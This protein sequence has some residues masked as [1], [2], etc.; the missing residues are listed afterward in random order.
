M[1]SILNL[2]RSLAFYCLRFLNDISKRVFHLISSSNKFYNVINPVT[3]VKYL[4][5]HHWVSGP[6]DRERPLVE[7]G[8]SGEGRSWMK[9]TSGIETL[10]W[11]L[12]L[13]WR[14]VTC[15]ISLP[16]E[17]EGGNNF[18]PGNSLI[19]LSSIWWPKIT[20]SESS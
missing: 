2:I 12:G 6:K 5:L 10:D 8:F 13:G 1:Y 11:L 19:K 14:H 18:K 20:C 15:A 16:R 17:F 3:R 9:K 7:G 4:I